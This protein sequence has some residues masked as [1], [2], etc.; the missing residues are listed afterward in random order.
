VETVNGPVT[1]TLTIKNVKNLNLRV[2]PDGEVDVSA[3]PRVPPE[4]A[5]RLIR[6]RSGWVLRAQARMRSR[7]VPAV[8]PDLTRG[9][10]VIFEAVE[11]LYPLV[12][13]L[14]IPKPEVTLR[15]MTSRWGSCHY[16]RRRI[17]LNR[18]L[19]AVP[20]E[21]LDYVVVHELTHFLC[22]NH[23]AQFYAQLAAF[24]P[25]WARRR[26]LLRTYEGLLRD[27]SGL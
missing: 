24:M 9:P 22:P 21:C 27:R 13:A 10:E 12:A 11:R 23:S 2:G 14:G 6:D 5:D 7:N 4:A 25:D 15:K 26:S 3:G 8:S 19:S 16:T 17:T 1:Y 20:T 18:A